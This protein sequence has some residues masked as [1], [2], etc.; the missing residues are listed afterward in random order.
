[1]QITF[2]VEGFIFQEKDHEKTV[3]ERCKPKMKGKISQPMA[4]NKL[5][6]WAICS[7]EWEITEY[8]FT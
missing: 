7:V 6:I 8:L 2:A 4:I 5:G 3:G 1:M